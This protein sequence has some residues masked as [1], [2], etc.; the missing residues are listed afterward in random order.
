M[1]HVYIFIVY[2]HTHIYPLLL[3]KWSFLKKL[4]HLMLFQKQV[5]VET[6][7]TYTEVDRRVIQIL[8]CPSANFSEHLFL[9]HLVY[10]LSPPTWPPP[11]PP[12]P[13]LPQST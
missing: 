5:I 9:A 11:P 4:F 10:S 6:C 8:M 3:H 7:Q 2:I 12:P 13:T 1:A